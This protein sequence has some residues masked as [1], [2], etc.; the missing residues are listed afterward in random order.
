MRALSSDGRNTYRYRGQH[1]QKWLV[2]TRYQ[3]FD[4][5]RWRCIWRIIDFFGIR[6]LIPDRLDLRNK[7]RSF[8]TAS[9]S[10]AITKKKS[11]EFVHYNEWDKSDW[12]ETSAHGT[13]NVVRYRSFDGVWSLGKGKRARCKAPGPCLNS[14]L[15]HPVVIRHRGYDA[16]LILL[17]M[18]QDT[19]PYCGPRPSAAAMPALTCISHQTSAD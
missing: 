19:R 1:T 11:F 9:K 2:V 17:Q 7:I 10:I 6:E 16:L 3:F 18:I 12:I 8:D 15:G 5:F 13:T 14:G 4:A